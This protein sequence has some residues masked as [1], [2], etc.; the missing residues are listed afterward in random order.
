MDEFSN[1]G[2]MKIFLMLFELGRD[3][4]FCAIKTELSK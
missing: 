2:F 3:R 1:I 4:D